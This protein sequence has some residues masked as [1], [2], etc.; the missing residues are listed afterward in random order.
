MA[1]FFYGG[2]PFSPKNAGLAPTSPNEDDST[3]GERSDGP[4]HAEACFSFG[5]PI[6]SLNRLSR[7]S[8]AVPQD[9]ARQTILKIYF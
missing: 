5:M 9:I 2:N 1:L 6:P 3:A 7:S 4:L 8:E